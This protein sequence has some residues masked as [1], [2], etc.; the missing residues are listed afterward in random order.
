MSPQQY[1]NTVTEHT[2]IAIEKQ[3]LDLATYLHQNSD[4]TPSMGLLSGQAGITLFFAYLS[5]AYDNPEYT[6]ITFDLLEKLGNAL[7]NETLDHGMSSGITGIAFVFQHLKNMGI[8]DPDEDLNLAAIDEFIN[9]G[10]DLDASIDNWDPLHGM[11][12]LGIYFLERNIETG[13]TRYLEKITDL[14]A[15]SRVDHNGYKLWIT[16]GFKNFSNDNY[17]FGMA[18]GMPGIL[19]FL[20]QVHQRGIRQELIE[21]IIS[22]CIPYILS[23][24][25]GTGNKCRFPLFVDVKPS[26]AD[27]VEFSRLGWCYGDLSVAFMLLHCGKAL[28]KAVWTE[29]GLQI[30]LL[31]AERNFE[32][33][34]CEDAP[35]CHGTAG[36]VHQF[37]RLYKFSGN[38]AF[39]NAADYW[40]A[41]TIKE[42]YKPESGG[43][44][45]NFLTYDL[46]SRKQKPIVNDGLLEGNAG[47]GLVYLS[48]NTN[49]QPN[50]DIIFLT[51]V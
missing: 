46:K 19:S 51:N 27:P 32:N 49:I 4:N 14:I 33:A 11:T 8:I 36:L 28:A 16:K 43:P 23:Q 9:Q 3:I 34:G 41:T 47:I 29:K 5:K 40:Y 42:F 44:A 35:F 48:Y 50:W 10:I 13:D 15:K 2:S 18:H 1:P 45:Y 31:A 26:D 25:F 17:N 24:E 37:N 12:G 21:E 20:A 6:T 38:S 22:N 7:A 39:K 30:A